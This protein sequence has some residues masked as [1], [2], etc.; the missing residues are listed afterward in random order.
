MPLID[1]QLVLTWVPG[2]SDNAE[3]IADAIRQAQAIAEAYCGFGFDSASY[4]EYYETPSRA[5]AIVL[6][7]RPVTAVSAVYE[8]ARSSSPTLLD[9]DD[10]YCEG[11]T[12]ILRRRGGY[13]SG[14]VR[15]QYT[16]G[17]DS[18]S[19]PADLQQALLDL[20]A[21]LLNQRGNVGVRA[22]AMDGYRV[23]YEGGLPERVRVVLDKYRKVLLA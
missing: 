6:R 21:W 7:H 17:W 1:E 20:V 18:T 11:D 4:D 3:R 23:D 12:G 10:Y 13:W 22:E 5:T 9:S 16:A 8:D 14:V 2:A 15:V 19:V